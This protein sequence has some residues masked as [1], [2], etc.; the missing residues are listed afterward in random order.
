[1]K[2]GTVKWFNLQKG[3]G[4][5]H[6]DDGS[7]NIFVHMSAIASAGVS[8]LNEGQRVIFEV[9]QDE[10]TGNAS[11]VSLK[12]LVFAM[13]PQ[14]DGSFA[15]ANPFDVIFALISSTMSPLEAVKQRV[16]QRTSSY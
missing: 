5:I 10:R 11:A 2:I 7:P 3:S 12:P 6:P 13:T 1:M 15:T 16:E 8:D 9:E 4:F 14:P